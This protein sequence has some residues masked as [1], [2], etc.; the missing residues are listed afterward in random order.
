M[1]KLCESSK[2]QVYAGSHSRHSALP[3][4]EHGATCLHQPMLAAWGLSTAESA[5][6][7][8]LPYILSTC[9]FALVAGS[10]ACQRQWGHMR[11]VLG[12]GHSA[13]HARMQGEHAAWSLRLSRIHAPLAYTRDDKQGFVNACIG[14]DC[15]YR[16]A[17]GI[18][19]IPHHGMDIAC[20]VLRQLPLSQLP[21]ALLASALL[22]SSL[23]PCCTQVFGKRPWSGAKLNPWLGHRS[24]VLALAWS[25]DAQ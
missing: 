3:P 1:E 24:W 16:I 13:A 8:A 14:K 5:E 12:F 9:A 10:A 2:S 4:Y 21:N 19:W 20:F 23:H 7:R 22:P 6:L 25:P 15:S 18:G 17:W 11:E